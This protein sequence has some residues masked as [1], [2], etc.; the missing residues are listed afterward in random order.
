MSYDYDALVTEFI[1]KRQQAAAAEAT[2][3]D[4]R[5]T[6]LQEAVQALE[7]LSSHCPMT[8]VLWI[9]YAAA[10]AACFQAMGSDTAT[11]KQAQRE[12]LA[13]G[14]VEFP[15]SLLLQC[16]HVQSCLDENENTDL[17]KQA[18]ET[19]IS[20]VGKGSYRK[21][22]ALV[23]WLY[24]KLADQHK[25]N[26]NLEAAYQVFFEQAL[27]PLVHVNDA[28]Q[29][30]MQ[31]WAETQVP[32]TVL[33][34]LETGRR[35]VAKVF[36]AA[37][38]DAQADDEVEAQ[39]HQAGILDHPHIVWKADG[40]IDWTSVELP[41]GQRYGMGY[42]EASLAR[43]FVS[44]A[45]SCTQQPAIND[46]DPG[47]QALQDYKRKTLPWS[48]YERGVAECPTVEFLWLSYIKDL[49]KGGSAEQRQ[50]Q[51]PA[52]I[53][54][55][56]RNCPYSIALVR[57]DLETM[58]QFIAEGLVDFEPDVLLQRVEAAWDRGFLP[59]GP[60]TWCDLVLRVVSVVRQTLLSLC[61][62]Q[63]DRDDKKK[64]AQDVKIDDE[65]LDEISYLREDVGELY[66]TLINKLHEN[67]PDYA[68]GRS[69]MLQE[70]TL[71][72]YHL[73][74]PL[75]L[76]DNQKE[77]SEGN[78]NA[79]EAL[80]KAARI[81]PHPDTYLTWIHFTQYNKSC[82]QNDSNATHIVQY[83]AHIRLAFV[84]AWQQVSPKATGQ[85]DF[86][87]ALADLAHEWIQWETLFG[88]AASLQ[89]AQ[90]AVQKRY[91]RIQEQQHKEQKKQGRPDKDRAKRRADEAAPEEPVRKKIKEQ[92]HVGTPPKQTDVLV[93][94]PVVE[95]KKEI[96]DKQLGST[97]DSK[98]EDITKK[99]GA[100][101]KKERPKVTIN[102]MEYPAHPF[103][104][105][106]S[107]LAQGVEDMDLVDLLRAKCGAI[108]HARIVREKGHG[109]T[110]SRGWGLVQFEEM[111]AVEKAIALSEQIGIH[112]K[113]VTID[114]SNTPAVSLVP[115]GMHRVNPKGEGRSSKRNEK[116]KEKSFMEKNQ[117]AK[118]DKIIA[119]SKPSAPR[120]D[121]LSLA[122]R[123]V[124]KRASRP[125]PK[126]T[127]ASK[128]T[129][130]TK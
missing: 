74:Q 109:K 112:E 56:C 130:E 85:R 39:L 12:A 72:D 123:G 47:L 35:L 61:F 98:E 18:L 100:K 33:G 30:S 104:V 9:Q 67:F 63:Y 113:I 128:E 120:P 114:R 59:G 82:T 76:G 69:R 41:T 73:L 46:E 42:G 92:Q 84:H 1:T 71:V 11:A 60:A 29:H 122:P 20:Q 24:R 4:A 19:A 15:G 36:T 115:P 40:D 75:K 32:P 101:S 103:T 99:E 21:A 91:Q 88:S 125:K 17:A 83:L 65:T 108:V 79:S 68:T 22:D 26:D 78:K 86:H 116:R 97:S 94:E 2:D 25:Q 66:E 127:I 58:Q 57:Q 5:L 118:P 55:A 87:T 16:R 34:A 52:V 13:L 93:A 117:P 8:P 38:S 31:I 102:G 81:H 90:N 54:R 23:A 121:V 51:L 45:T 43:A 3:A 96:V 48:I 80:A 95:N 6:A 50:K 106:V 77:V 111:D 37:A 89:R 107:N 28:L 64:V 53:Q 10:L 110:Q 27:V 14:L 119:E 129:H 124:L 105:R 62:P 70:H 49:R 7:T 44:Y 126:L